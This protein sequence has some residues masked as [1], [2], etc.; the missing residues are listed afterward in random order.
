M[1]RWLYSLL[2]YLALP[3]VAL[4]FMARGWRHV[5]YR[6][7]LREHLAWRPAPRADGPLWMHAASVGEVRAL[8]ALVH[9]LGDAA[10]PLLIT[11]GTPTGRARATELFGARHEV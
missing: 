10:A 11:V 6:G 8:A 4:R 3:A 2:L 9:A 7:G 1:P 5:A